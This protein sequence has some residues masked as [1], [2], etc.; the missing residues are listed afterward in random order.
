MHLPIGYFT[1]TS[2]NVALGKALQTP[3]HS[4][5]DDS[6]HL[7]RTMSPL[8]SVTINK[9][10]VINSYCIIP[11]LTILMLALP[12]ISIV[13]LQPY[14]SRTTGGI[15]EMGEELIKPL[16]VLRVRLPLTLTCQELPPAL[17]PIQQQPEYLTIAKVNYCKWLLIQT[18]LSLSPRSKT[19]PRMD[20]SQYTMEDLPL[21]LTLF[22]SG[23]NVWVTSIIVRSSQLHECCVCHMS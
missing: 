2:L 14:C 22:L 11:Q 19:N 6:A 12:G 16:S 17:K 10:R 7:H 13:W 21:Q 20:C 4:P 5:W 3:A 23:S 1:F 18:S 15:V 9:S 8:A